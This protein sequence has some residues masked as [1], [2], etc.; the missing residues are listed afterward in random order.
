MLSL[1]RATGANNTAAGV[2]AGSPPSA[3]TSTQHQQSDPLASAVPAST[4]GQRHRQRVAARALVAKWYKAGGGSGAPPQGSPQPTAPAVD[5]EQPAER[6]CDG[7]DECPICLEP[8][9]PP[10]SAVCGPCC[11]HTLH[12]DCGERLVLHGSLS[13]PQCRASLVPP[14]LT[15]LVPILE[16]G[17]RRVGRSSSASG[18]GGTHAAMPAAG[19]IPGVEARPGS[20]LTAADWERD[21]DDDFMDGDLDSDALDFSFGRPTPWRMSFAQREALLAQLRADAQRASVMRNVCA[22]SAYPCSWAHIGH[23]GHMIRD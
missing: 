10:E 1:P 8:L 11:G 16:S 23:I 5:E 2:T 17:G 14:E 19:V 18:S 4:S 21:S 9:S 3:A 6:A 20:V 13:C 22:K 12:R 15:Y 7:A